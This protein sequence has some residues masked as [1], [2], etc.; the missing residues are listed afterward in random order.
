MSKFLIA[1]PDVSEEERQERVKAARDDSTLRGLMIVAERR[2]RNAM[3]D[4]KGQKTSTEMD[5]RP[6]R[7]E[8]EAMAVA[9]AIGKLIEERSENAAPTE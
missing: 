1:A 6:C 7:T 9:K 5:V 4:K 2:T 3:F 8:D